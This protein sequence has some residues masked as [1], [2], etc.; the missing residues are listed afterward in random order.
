[1]LLPNSRLSLPSSHVLLQVVQHRPFKN[2]KCCSLTASCP[3]QSVHF[4]IFCPRSP[5]VLFS[6]SYIKNGGIIIKTNCF[7]FSLDK[8]KNALLMGLTRSRCL[9]FIAVKRWPVVMAFGVILEHLAAPDVNKWVNILLLCG[10]I[11]GRFGIVPLLSSLQP[12]FQGRVS[13]GS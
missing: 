12:A 3:P 10:I 4:N 5:R 11:C 9:T 2:G 8:F 7:T 13:D 1:M 6:L